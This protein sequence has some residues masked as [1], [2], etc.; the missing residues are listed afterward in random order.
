MS[1]KNIRDTILD[2]RYRIQYKLVRET[3]PAIYNLLSDQL[4]YNNEAWFQVGYFLDKAIQLSN[5]LKSMET[6]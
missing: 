1:T 4:F 3:P 6:E 5:K 2:I